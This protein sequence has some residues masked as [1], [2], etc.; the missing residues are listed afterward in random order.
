MRIVKETVASFLLLRK[1]KYDNVAKRF[2]KFLIPKIIVLLNYNCP[3]GI[4]FKFT[5]LKLPSKF[6][7]NVYILKQTQNALELFATC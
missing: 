6:Q 3:L 1:A 5:K 2:F 4:L 7:F